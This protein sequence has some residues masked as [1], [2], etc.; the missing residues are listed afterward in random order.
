[1]EHSRI[2]FNINYTQ[3]LF[4]FNFLIFQVNLTVN[5]GVSDSDMS[6]TLCVTKPFEKSVSG[7][8]SLCDLPSHDGMYLCNI[9]EWD[10][11]IFMNI[12]MMCTLM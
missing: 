2:R 10:V 9:F 8:F 3:F 11:C 6:S 12:F 4:I 7:G 5:N 1:M